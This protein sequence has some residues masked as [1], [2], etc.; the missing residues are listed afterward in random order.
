MH[1]MGERWK[2]C[3]TGYCVATVW[4]C[5]SSEVDG[6]TMD[7]NYSVILQSREEGANMKAALC[8]RIF[9]V[10]SHKHVYCAR[11]VLWKRVTTKFLCFSQ[12]TRQAGKGAQAQLN[13]TLSISLLTNILMCTISVFHGFNPF[14]CKN[15]QMGSLIS[16]NYR[17]Q[18]KL[19]HWRREREAVSCKHLAP[20]MFNWINICGATSAPLEQHVFFSS[21]ICA[22]LRFK[23]LSCWGSLNLWLSPCSLTLGNMFPS[24]MTR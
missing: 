14:W 10:C 7:D 3:T 17:I 5:M 20:Q 19:S 22:L 2:C 1:G 23:L 13:W 16:S 8:I 15:V 24:R 11:L 9:A 12:N 21:I 6:K 18:Y 4:P